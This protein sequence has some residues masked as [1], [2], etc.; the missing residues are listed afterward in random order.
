MNTMLN[1]RCRHGSMR[2][3]CKLCY[4]SR[5]RPATTRERAWIGVMAVSLIGYV[6]MGLWMAGALR[7][8]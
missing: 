8:G 1:A 6:I 5:W 7:H 3:L 2:R 4:R